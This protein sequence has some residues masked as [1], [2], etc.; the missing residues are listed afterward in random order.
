MAKLSKGAKI[1]IGIGVP[2]VVILLIV[3]IVFIVLFAGPSVE[4]N[5]PLAEVYMMGQMQRASANPNEDYTLVES[6]KIWSVEDMIDGASGGSI[7]IDDLKNPE[8][9]NALSAEDKA[10]VVAWIYRTAVFNYSQVVNKAWYLDTY[11][12]VQAYDT[13]GVDKVTV[14][15]RSPYTDIFGENGHYF[16]NNAGIAGFNLGSASVGSNVTNMLG[17]N[18]QS[19]SS[20]KVN[21]GRTGKNPAVYYGTGSEELA[22]KNILGAWCE[23]FEGAKIDRSAGDYK[24]S[25]SNPYSDYSDAPW[26][27]MA[28]DDGGYLS[29]GWAKY[30]MDDP[31]WLDVEKT[32]FEYDAARDRF[33]IKFVFNDDDV[34]DAGRNS[35]NTLINDTK[36]YI[37]LTNPTYT[38][39]ENTLE[40]S[41]SGLIT[42]WAKVEVLES[43]AAKIVNK[44]N[45]SKGV[46]SNDQINVFS[47]DKNDCDAMKWASFYMPELRDVAEFAS[48]E[49]F[50]KYKPSVDTESALG[51]AI[52]EDMQDFVDTRDARIQEALGNKK[53]A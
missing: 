49:T 27:I 28:E 23:N 39:C 33:V 48:Y 14:I 53:A 20:A 4:Y 19:I 24:P 41:A 43:G 6:G 29:A 5:K 51:K 42:K 31:E 38:K 15:V 9:F 25:T 40:I 2:V 12:T 52:Y 26:E 32:S 1:A 8:D 50:D 22:K 3:A 17:Y 36:A 7:S 37:T 11:S 10:N 30:S 47:Y 18:Y 16:Q 45:A 34:Q 13:L 46:A 44:F 21:A 35:M